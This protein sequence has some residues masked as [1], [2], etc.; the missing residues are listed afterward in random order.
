M[1][2]RDTRGPAPD[3]AIL[4]SG[5]EAG[6]VR[7][8]GLVAKKGSRDA[9]RA[10]REMAEWLE[11]R[12]IEVH[13]DDT[14]ARASGGGD[15]PHFDFAERYDLVVVLGGDGTLLAVARSAAQGV[16]ILGVNLGSLGFLTEVGRAE[17][18][19]A[20]VQVL[21][22][23]FAIEERPLLDV[24]L[25]RNG[26][27]SAS[28]RVFNDAVVTKGALA[29]IIEMLLLVDGNLVARFRADGLIIAT[30]SGSTAYN[31]SAGGP[32]VHP[33]LPVVLLT[34]ICPHALTLR[35]VAVPSSGRVEVRLASE[36]EEV[37]LTLDGQEGTSLTHGD[38]VAV[39][40]SRRTARLIKAGDRT[41]Y[42]SLR[43][44]LRWGGLTT[45]AHL[46]S[47]VGPEAF[48]A[49]PGDAGPV[50]D[51]GELQRG[52]GDDENSAAP[53]TPGTDGGDGAGDGE[54]ET[55]ESDGDDPAARNRG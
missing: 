3:P 48:P 16:P 31:L 12:G 20:L 26:G 19:P 4:P 37:F 27:D 41:F 14:L 32:I 46:G 49:A 5:V 44:K 9:M 42:D 8:V 28:Y 17:A 13:R 18:Y 23:D 15:G 50:T 29:R 36:G 11:R 22:G 7:R 6:W 33:L 34:P 39:T 45:A 24:G 1:S 47:D 2:G 43:G 52:L 30:P 38:T 10:G 53:E 55:G 54:G 40:R 21:E 25:V 35:P 51:L